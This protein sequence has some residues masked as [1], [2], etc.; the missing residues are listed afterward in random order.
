MMDVTCLAPNVN[1]RLSPEPCN[2][3]RDEEPIS[4]QETAEERS[5]RERNEALAQRDALYVSDEF[6]DFWA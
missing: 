3:Q 5:D 4:R 2:Q 1:I 6:D